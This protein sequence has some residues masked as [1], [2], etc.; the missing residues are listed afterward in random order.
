MYL[1]ED[2]NRAKFIID[3]SAIEVGDPIKVGIS[4]LH[5]TQKH[6]NIPEI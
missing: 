2:F 1:S 4:L 3:N 6:S 5:T